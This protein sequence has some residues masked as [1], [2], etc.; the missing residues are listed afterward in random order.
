MKRIL[1]VKL[2]SLGDIVF[3][4]PLIND[5]RHAFPSVSI[6]WVVDDSCRS[7]LEWH[8]DINS[9]YSPP[10]REFK[11]KKRLKDFFRIIKSII[12]LRKNRYDAVIDI[13]GVYK[14]AIATWLS[15]SDI[16][17]GFQDH[18]LGESGARLAYNYRLASV[19]A[20]SVSKGLRQLVSQALRYD[21]VSSI[22]YGI[23]A[24]MNEILPVKSSQPPFALLFHGT[25][26][27]YKKWSEENWGIFA[28]YLLSCGVSVLLPWGNHHELE[29]AKRIQHSAPGCSVL[30]LLSVNQ[31]A[32]LIS[33]AA[34][35]AGVDTGLVHISYA[36]KKPTLQIFVATSCERY[37]PCNIKNA[38]A[39]SG[40]NKSPPSFS[41][42]CEGLCCIQ[43]NTGDISFIC[44]HCAKKNSCDINHYTV[45]PAGGA[46]F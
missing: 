43:R 12:A 19:P 21:L 10:L 16:K 22:D 9:I 1:I 27:E 4:L 28:R 44:T 31:L 13:H 3:A 26:G 6:D 18:D 32:I 7:V 25:A 38:W 45:D 33:N 8:A 30:P 15:K 2:T 35:V 37:G 41:D 42:A 34:L 40:I 39:I 17:W 23:L 14:S 36:L 46:D 29:V 20:G 24:P 5:I 11:K